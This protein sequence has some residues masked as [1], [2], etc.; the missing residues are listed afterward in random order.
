MCGII[1]YVGTREV[2]PVLIG[3]LKKLEYRGYDSAGVAVVNGKRR[4]RRARRGKAVEPR[5]EAVGQSSCTA[6]SAWATRAGPRTASR[7]RTTPIRIATAPATSSS[8][9]TASSRT[10][11]R[12]SSACR[13]AGTRV[14]D[15]D[16]HRSRRPPHR[17][18][19]QGRDEVRR[20]G[21]E[22]RSKSSKATTRW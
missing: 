4:R 8:S 1:G 21:E 14:Q 19:M 16:R 18:E 9:T 15:R 7:T 2:V 5:S 3:G 12:S 13:S 20:C 22:D 10:S 6:R 17:R 11:S